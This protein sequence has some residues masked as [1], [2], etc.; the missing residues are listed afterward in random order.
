MRRRSNSKTAAHP[1]A[2]D[3]NPQKNTAAAIP[4]GRLMPGVPHAAIHFGSEWHGNEPR[5]SKLPAKIKGSAVAGKI[6]GQTSPPPK[7]L[8]CLN[9]SDRVGFRHIGMP[10]PRQRLAVQDS[11]ALLQAP[12]PLNK[13]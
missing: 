3:H 7:A 6:G 13:P 5:S 4:A 2:S 9:Y 8:I 11:F 1:P 12:S 10:T